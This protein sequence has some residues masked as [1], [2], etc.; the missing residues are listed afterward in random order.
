[1]WGLVW[2]LLSVAHLYLSAY[3]KACCEEQTPKATHP[4]MKLCLS[5]CSKYTNYSK[6][7]NYHN[8]G[9]FL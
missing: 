6:F 7:N 1:M 3:D 4:T 2:L 5:M 9:G 8:R